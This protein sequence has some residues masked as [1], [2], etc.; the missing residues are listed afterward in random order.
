MLETAGDVATELDG[1]SGLDLG[2]T[3]LSADSAVGVAGLVVVVAGV[4]PRNLRRPANFEGDGVRG[5]FSGGE[6]ASATPRR[7]SFS[8]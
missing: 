2:G 5:L 4:P 8:L 1:A 6:V 3:T 7:F